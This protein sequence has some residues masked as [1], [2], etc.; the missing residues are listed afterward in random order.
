MENVLIL[1]LMVVLI[2]HRNKTKMKRTEV[3][4]KW[5]TGC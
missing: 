4:D 5:M 1:E 3:V 2:L